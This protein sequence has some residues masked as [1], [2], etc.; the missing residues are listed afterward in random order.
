MRTRARAEQRRSGCAAIA[1][2]CAV[3][4]LALPASAS[5]FTFG[6]TVSP[7]GP[8]Q[9]IFDWSNDR[10]QSNNIPDAP[11][12]A[13]RDAR[14]RI[15]LLVTHWLNYRV[16]GRSFD[17]LAREC[18][19]LMPSGE[20][21]DPATYNN[22]EWV[23]SIYTE[24]GRTVYGLTSN[25]YQ[26][27]LFVNMCPSGN[28]FRCLYLSITGV[29]SKNYGDDY[30]NQANPLVRSTPYQYFPDT[31]PYGVNQPSNIIRAHDG[32]YYVLYKTEDYLAQENGT[33]LM[34][35]R[36]LRDAASWRHWQGTSF[37]GV[38]KN[39]YSVVPMQRAEPFTCKP[40]DFASIEA[41]AHSLTW[42]TYL[43]KYL[44]VGGAG[45]YEPS[46][47]H[48]VYGIYYSLSDDL[49]NWTDRELMVE[50]PL[51]YSWTC[52]QEFPW[53]FPSVIDRDSR[54]RSFTTSDRDFDLYYTLHNRGNCLVGLDRDLVRV[55][56]R[57]N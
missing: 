16:I 42:N 41:M 20:S 36:D 23:G 33:C 15:Q 19:N 10:C 45:K 39:P 37:S 57:F 5:A 1:F 46:V 12:H 13:I 7:T 26:G 49:I 25:E 56:V 34:R 3:L 47:G 4:A 27:N 53:G 29:V 2:A 52:G 30:V 22:K 43:D 32:Y 28:Y 21:G 51:V 18:K 48:N 11:A 50:V 35:T 55:P 44:L 14:N 40:V 38:R 54:S 24:D 17:D 31:G 6:P 9:T 8:H